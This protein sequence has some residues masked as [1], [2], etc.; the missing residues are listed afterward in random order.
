MATVVI[1][2][3]DTFY[4]ALMDPKKVKWVLVCSHTIVGCASL[5]TAV[6]QWRK[7][8]N[9]KYILKFSDTAHNCFTLDEGRE[10]AY[11][12]TEPVSS[13]DQDPINMD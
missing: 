10:K 5:G 4:H 13:P 3:K 6:N 12:V 7:E 1:N 2:H 11:L 8:A 9:P